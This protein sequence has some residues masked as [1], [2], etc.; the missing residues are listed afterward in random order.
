MTRSDLLTSVTMAVF[1]LVPDARG[2]AP[3]PCPR[4]QRVD[5]KTRRPDLAGVLCVTGSCSNAGK[6]TV[7]EDV[8]AALAEAGRP[9]VA[10]KVTRTHLETCPREN[11]DCG[12]CDDLDV[13]Y[14]IVRAR[15]E[16]DVRGKDTARYLAAGA[17]EVLWLIVDPAH[18]GAGVEGALRFVPD[19]ALLLAEGN[20]F[21][22]HLDGEVLT[23]M[24]MTD[25]GKIK[26]SAL[27][28]IDRASAFVGG[29]EVRQAAQSVLREARVHEHPWVSPDAIGAWVLARLEGPKA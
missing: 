6:T 24:A 21:R 4:E 9:A 28:V 12:V 15:S 5:W 11:D 3:D 19:G 10:L 1:D 16:L 7:C 13:P 17:A 23:I 20:S 27:H 29:P 22:D 14:R 26:P 8:L 2:R 25:E 18:M